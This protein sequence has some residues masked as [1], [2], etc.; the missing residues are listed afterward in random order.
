MEEETLVKVG[1]NKLGHFYTD[2]VH[3]VYYVYQKHSSLYTW[4][5]G[6]LYV[7]IGAKV[8]TGRETVIQ[9]V[10]KQMAAMGVLQQ[11]VC[12]SLACILQDLLSLSE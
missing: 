2:R 3:L 10:S 1:A 8:K 12:T 5:E 9:E 6:M 4:M 7:W 11:I